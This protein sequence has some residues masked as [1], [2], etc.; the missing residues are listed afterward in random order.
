MRTQL[1]GQTAFAKRVQG[2]GCGTG[3]RIE[4]IAMEFHEYRKDQKHLELVEILRKQG[5]ET[6]VKKTFVEYNL[7]GF[8]TLWAWRRSKS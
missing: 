8:G 2:R 3:N 7:M 1:T 5:F 4:R 6:E